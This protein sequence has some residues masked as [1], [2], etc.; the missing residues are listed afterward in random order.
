MATQNTQG[1]GRRGGH[2]FFRALAVNTLGLLAAT[3]ACGLIGGIWVS[4]SMC[5]EETLAW[6]ESP[7]ISMEA[8]PWFGI[9]TA[10]VFSGIILV[11]VFISGKLL[12]DRLQAR[13]W[14]TALIFIGIQLV[15]AFIGMHIAMQVDIALTGAV[16]SPDKLII[17]ALLTFTFTLLFNITYYTIQLNRELRIAESSAMHSELK[18][19]RAQVNPHFLF[20]ALNSIAALIRVRP[21]E[22]E[23]VTEHLADLFR[24]SLRSSERAVVTMADELESVRLYLTIES[25]RFRDRLRVHYEIAPGLRRALVPSL[26]LQPLVENAVKHGLNRSEDTCRISVSGTIEGDTVRLQV[27]DTGPGFH[28]LDRD[29]LYARGT[30]LSNV[31][32]RLSL[33]FGRRADVHIYP[34]GIELEFPLMTEGIQPESVGAAAEADLQPAL[35]KA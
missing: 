30:G 25:S 2:G 22:A 14:K 31:H 21:E 27:H 11:L 19:L 33:L 17:I 29:V 23:E 32:Q 3:L 13:S 34:N 28:T 1:P 24:Y 7:V 9:V 4:M 10:T 20:N 12:L 8:K 15:V 35:S 5:P 16:Y 26:V 18:T 6:F